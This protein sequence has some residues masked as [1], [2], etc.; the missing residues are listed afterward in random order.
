M[1][2]RKKGHSI[3]QT[4]KFIISVSVA[5]LLGMS[6]SAT[7]FAKDTKKVD[8]GEQNVMSVAWYQT[9]AEAKAL[10][11][12]GYNVA[13][14]NIDQA[15][16]TDKP[17]AVIL[18]IDETVLDNSPYQ[19]YNALHDRSYPDGWDKWVKSA[20]A[21][22]VPGAKD[23][24]TYANERGIQLYYVSDRSDSQLKATERN[25]KAQGIPQANA[26][27]ILLKGK[28]DRTKEARRAWIAQNYDVIMLIGDNLSDFNDPD[29]NTVK[30]RDV[31]VATN[32]AQFGNKYIILPNPM[33]GNW[34][35]ALYNND[36]QKSA[37]VRAKLRKSHLTYYDPKT[38]TLKTKNVTEK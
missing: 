26:E 20:K 19:A 21:K 29:Q 31:D 24:L 17:K 22:P 34:E 16:T 30:G 4:K 36:Y 38:N 10:Y 25:L 14:K 28:T 37:K 32:A 35:A 9:S 3:L 18:D 15:E 1:G 12:Q 33:Y 7:I 8:L 2:K 5:L 13:K 23:F 27:H 6:S 11:L